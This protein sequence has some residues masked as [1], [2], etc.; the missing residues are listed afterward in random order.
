MSDESK[1]DELLDLWEESIENGKEIGLEDLCCDHPNLIDEVKAKIEAIRRMDSCFQSFEKAPPPLS[2][3]AHQRGPSSIEIKSKL[4]DLNLHD[5]GGLGVVYKAKDEELHRDVAVKFLNL[6]V[7]QSEEYRQRFLQEA[8]ITGRLD[9]PGVVPVYASGESGDQQPFYV[10]RFI[11]GDTYD[12]VIRSYHKDKSGRSYTQGQLLRQKLLV[13]LASV[14]KTIG[15]AHNRGIIHRD[16][17]P[18]NI[19][20]GKYGETLVV[21]W[22]LAIPFQRDGKFRVLDEKTLVPQSSKDNVSREG[23]G[24]PVFMSPEQAAGKE[25][26]GPASDIYSLGVVLYRALTG[27]FAFDGDSPIT[28][29][30]AIMK[31]DFVAPRQIDNTIPADLESICLKAMSLIPQD[32]YATATEMADDIE[33]FLADVPVNAFRYTLMQRIGRF[34]KQKQSLFLGLLTAAIA[35]TLAT[36]IASISFYKT[37]QDAK[38]SLVTARISQIDSLN[39]TCRMTAK[40]IQYNLEARLIAMEQLAGSMLLIDLIESA[41]KTDSSDQIK[42]LLKRNRDSIQRRLPIV[43][44]VLLNERGETIG[45]ASDTEMAGDGSLWCWPYFH[46]GEGRLDLESDNVPL[47]TDHAALSPVYFCELRDLELCSLSVPVKKPN[48]S[49]IGVL[50]MDIQMGQFDPLIDNDSVAGASNQRFVSLVE[51]RGDLQGALLHHPGLKNMSTDQV[52]K[53]HVCQSVL[54]NVLAIGCD[55]VQP[56]MISDYVDPIGDPYDGMWNSVALPIQFRTRQSETLQC[57]WYLMVQDR[58]IKVG[59]E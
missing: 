22:G 54:E 18:K 42:T 26:L 27:K 38:N 43:S 56:Q 47:P 49:I 13:Q 20:L 6:N 15:Y 33:N 9:H 53:I 24:T 29:R 48:G 37:R 57:G 25:D 5:R 12:D 7:A 45:A 3:S 17:K 2:G 44:L 16:I 55:Q 23:E 50:V 11:G 21:D 52:K 51:T 59:R 41:D 14:C 36:S 31:G 32:R 10:M 4:L 35:L 1:I 19:M 46:G 40:S 58:P 30:T 39:M 28:I 34:I 8:E